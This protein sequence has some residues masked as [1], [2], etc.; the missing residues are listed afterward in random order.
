MR[1][2]TAIWT[3]VLTLAAAVA[4]PVAAGDVRFFRMNSRKAFLGGTL[5]GLS[6]DPLGTLRLAD[7]AARLATIGEP[8]LFSAA[9]H[10]DGPRQHYLG[11]APRRDCADRFGHLFPPLPGRRLGIGD[12]AGGLR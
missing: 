7:R 9:P 4:A 1:R 8:F 11:E 3:V 5:D 6:V 12:V 2:Q 10:P